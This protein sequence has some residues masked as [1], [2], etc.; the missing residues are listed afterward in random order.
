M[1]SDIHWWSTG[2]LTCASPRIDRAGKP[3]LTPIPVAGPLQELMGIHKVSTYL[4]DLSPPPRI[5]PRRMASWRGSLGRY[6]TC[7]PK[8]W[9]RVGETGI[10]VFPMSCWPIELISPQ[11]STQERPFFLLYGRVGLWERPT[12]P[13]RCCPLC[14]KD[15]IHGGSG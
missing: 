14:T 5:I 1:R 2:C 9:R 3:P 4:S 8:Q 12:D 11:E 15:T 10:N 7:W 6:R 13:N